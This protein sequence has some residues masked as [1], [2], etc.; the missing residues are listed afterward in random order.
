MKNINI[1]DG[2]GVVRG[3]CDSPSYNEQEASYSVIMSL[4]TAIKR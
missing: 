4:L 3:Y 2:C 1:K